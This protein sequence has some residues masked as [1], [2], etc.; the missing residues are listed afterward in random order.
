MAR[1]V[2][3][4]EIN[5]PDFEWLIATYRE[6]FPRGIEVSQP[7]MPFAIVSLEGIDTPSPL[8]AMLLPPPSTLGVVRSGDD[9]DTF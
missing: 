3:S 5:D 8:Q 2:Y 7:G 4:H 1:A 6:R 9:T